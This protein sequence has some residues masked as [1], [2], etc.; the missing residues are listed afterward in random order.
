M[1]YARVL[2]ALLPL[3]FLLNAL[4]KPIGALPPVG[5]L[6]SPFHGFWQNAE[7]TN[8]DYG[9]ELN[10]S[11]LKGKAQVY[12]DERLVPHVFAE[13]EEDL[14]Y[15][16]GYLHARFRLFQIDLQTR[17][18]EGRASEFAGEVALR[19][20]REQRRLGMRYAAE[21]ALEA[22]ERD[23][24]SKQIFDAYT[25]G[26]NTYIDNLTFAEMPLEYKLLGVK[27]ERWSNIRTALLLKMMA[28]N[29]SSSTEIDLGM[30]N[31]KSVFL[32]EEL[33]LLYPQV[34]DSLM[35]I[36]PRGTE[37]ARPGI[38]PVRPASADSALFGTMAREPVS[39][40]EQHAP[41]PNNGSNNWVLA[42]SKTRSGAPI[43]CNDPHLELSLPSIWY[44]MQLHGPNTNSYGA[45]LPGSPFV[46][47]GF[48][49]SIAWGV[50]NAQRDVKDYYRV[51]F[52][53]AS[54]TE[55]WFDGRWQQTRLR[56]E[57]IQV[58][59]KGVIYD[60]VAYTNMGPVMYDASFGDT[61]SKGENLAVRWT[62]HDPSNE[63]KTFYLLNRAKNYAEYEAAIQ[64]FTCP[65]QNFVFASKT[66]DIAIWQQGR[67]PARWPDQGLYVMPGEDSTYFWQGY[68]PYQENPHALNPSTGFLESANQ[69]PVDETYPY[70]IPG[71]YIT[72]RGVTIE[73]KLQAMQDVSVQDVM[74]LHSDY[75]NSL[76]EDVRP[77]L[78]EY[79]DRTTLT[80]RESRFLE[81]F[82]QWDL[83]ATPDSKGQTIY[84]CWYDSLEFF[85][86][87]D[88]LERVKPSA[89]LPDEQTTMEWL[90][91]E[92][93]KM[94][95]LDNINTPVIE[96][97][98]DVV[99]ASLKAASLVLQD[100]ES[101]GKLNW[102]LF[103][104]SSVN[105]LLRDA[106]PSFARKK[107]RVGGNGN[108][109]NAITKSHGPSWRMVVHLTTDMEAYGIYPGGQNGN[110]GSRFYDDYI[111]KWVQGKYNR[112]WLMRATDSDKATW[113]L[114]LNPS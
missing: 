22:V 78:L 17:A 86:W 5:P 114:T 3:I 60:T 103:K 112:L 101:Q 21:N 39:A 107:L 79:V 111:D 30:T 49:D 108:I 7:A 71:R 69:R 76:A 84:Q 89:P 43:L 34:H 63:G 40:H 67:F 64:H 10:L 72:P 87:R 46:I 77:I 81:L 26:V 57:A 83:L 14:Y 8:H 19:F 68:I 41:D 82:E 42:G 27:P 98:S 20:D 109:V 48:N 38:E 99:T 104:E 85:I 31:A 88:E 100:Y 66:G 36:I 1:K 50:T 75:F 105:H 62:G 37:F 73:K 13:N 97:I 91:R 33:R 58:K 55:Y 29:L 47:I 52:R 11:G 12:F 80:P 90:A 32:P 61:L 16:Q 94:P 53:D 110:P 9:G 4:N 25:R 96:T 93:D 59:G 106:L 6:L 35:P 28:R 70:F 95:F 65:G 15:L 2:L 56:V 51:R 54:K 44:E 24:V 102:S 74:D 92:R 113:T 23:P 45:S 18:A